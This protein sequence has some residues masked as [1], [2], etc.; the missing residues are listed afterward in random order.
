MDAW[1]DFIG[2]Y[3]EIGVSE[4]IFRWPQDDQLSTFER[5]AREVIPVLRLPR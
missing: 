4:L 5:V 3:R 2:R 1:Q